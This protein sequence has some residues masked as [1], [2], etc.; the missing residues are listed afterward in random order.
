VV[1]LHLVRGGAVPSILR[2]LRPDVFLTVVSPPDAHGRVSFGASVSYALQALDHVPTVIAEVHPAMPRVRGRT[3]VDSS[4]FAALVEPETDALPV[5]N[6][7][8][9]TDEDTRIAEHVRALIPD[10]A[11]LQVGFGGVP[12]SLL[13]ILAED[14]P[15]G[16]RL[17]GMGIEAMVPLVERLGVRP[18][19]VGGEMLG[20][21]RLY[22]FAH[23]NPMIEHHPN[24]EL[25]SVPRLASIP[26]F[27]SINSAVEVDLTGQTNAEWAGG[28][29]ISGPGGGFDFLDA[30]T[31]SV[32]G[33][34]IIALSATTRDGRSTI[35]RSLQAGAPVTSPRHAVQAIVTE[36]GV[37]DLR[38]LTVAQR[39]EAL[40][41][42]AAP[43][44][45]DALADAADDLAAVD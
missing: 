16:L 1:G 33:L 25:L 27:V 19:Y 9:M 10:G 30:A 7:R 36:H 15:P 34:S 3:M 8:P 37:A 20:T 4:R 6:T 31:L 22:A 11:T 43:G 40:I 28:R 14:P 24:S 32:D 35:V 29:Q 26:R 17:L 5:H 38:A 41:A 39:A 45:R 12:E 42:I 13:G 44:H 21:D 2:R 18:G 23:D